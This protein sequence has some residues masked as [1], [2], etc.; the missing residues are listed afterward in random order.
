MTNVL[1]EQHQVC[2]EFL[3]LAPASCVKIALWVDQVELEFANAQ[4]TGIGQ[5]KQSL[6]QRAVDFV[7]CL[8]SGQTPEILDRFFDYQLEDEAVTL[9]KEL[10]EL[11][12]LVETEKFA[13]R[14]T[15]SYLAKEFNRCL[16]SLTNVEEMWRTL[17]LAFVE[18]AQ[19]TEKQRQLRNLGLF[20]LKVSGDAKNTLDGTNH[21]GEIIK[22]STQRLLESSNFSQPMIETDMLEKCFEF[23]GL[24]LEDETIRT[25]AAETPKSLGSKIF[26]ESMLS[27]SVTFHSLLLR[28][29]LQDMPQILSRS[30]IFG[31]LPCS[32]I[33]ILC[34]YARTLYLR[35]GQ[36]FKP[37]SRCAIA[38][39]VGSLDVT[40]ERNGKDEVI[41][42]DCSTVMGEAWAL[43]DKAKI[44]QVQAN[45]VSVIALIPSEALALALEIRP[46]G[47]RAMS[48]AFVKLCSSSNHSSDLQRFEISEIQPLCVSKRRIA[49]AESSSAQ[50]DVVRSSP[51]PTATDDTCYMRL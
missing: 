23:L 50:E 42:A 32:S 33:M 48:M 38:V 4:G 12:N 47:F 5:K 15:R 11:I 21:P 51:I 28:Q 40:Y 20:H 1:Q 7:A 41:Q 36:I 39:S 8:K 13:S 45:T 18:V 46:W 6:E 22:V 34:Q 49:R 35:K 25:I 31:V 10:D 16:M 24:Y 37:S 44:T 19:Y 26:P 27:S 29:D 2:K 3:E 43:L 9:H 30:P 17:S 14:K